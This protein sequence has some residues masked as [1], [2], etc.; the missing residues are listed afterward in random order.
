MQDVLCVCGSGRQSRAC[1][2]RFIQ[3]DNL[4]NNAEELMR[5][6]YTAY[7][8][9]DIAYI[10]KTMRSEALV[11]FDPSET[12][13]WA[14]SVKWVRLEVLSS[15]KINHDVATVEFKAY[16]KENGRMNIL[17]EKS[18]FEIIDSQWYYVGICKN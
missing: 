3:Q 12:Y 4:P 8:L 17:H 11:G 5:S 1:C 6:R 15:C 10:T 16:Y 9:A 7:T 2:I 18:L 14:S 13:T